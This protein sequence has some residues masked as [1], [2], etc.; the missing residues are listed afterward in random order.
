MLFLSLAYEMVEFLEDLYR[1]LV[2]AVFNVQLGDKAFKAD[3]K[4]ADAAIK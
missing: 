3:V 1:T 4:A 2:E